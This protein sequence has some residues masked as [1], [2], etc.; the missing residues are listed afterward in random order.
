MRKNEIINLK[1]QNESLMDQINKINVAI[2]S[3]NKS[4]D[5]D[6]SK[7][8]VII[9]KKDYNFIK[10]AI[11]NTMKKKIKELKKYIKQLLMVENHLHFIK[12][13][14]VYIIL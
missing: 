11:E 8:S 6:I 13:V 2:N 1:N 5:I 12:N 3:I 9:E 10:E 7:L 14:M 4:P